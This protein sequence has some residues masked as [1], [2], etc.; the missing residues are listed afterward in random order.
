M[1]ADVP[2]H[3]GIDKSAVVEKG[4]KIIQRL[5]HTHTTTLLPNLTAYKS[6]GTYGASH[7]K[8]SRPEDLTVYASL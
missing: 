4:T 2:V 8:P 7:T 6:I 1:L 5:Q 3:A